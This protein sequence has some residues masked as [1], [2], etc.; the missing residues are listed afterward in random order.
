MDKEIIEIMTVGDLGLCR[1]GGWGA[2]WGAG[3]CCP[4]LEHRN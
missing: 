4:C 1:G 2:G 3:H